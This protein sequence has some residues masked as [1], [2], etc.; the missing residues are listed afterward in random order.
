VNEGFDVHSLSLSEI[1]VQNGLQFFHS[2]FGL[3]DVRDGTRGAELGKRI[4]H[5]DKRG[6]DVVDGKGEICGALGDAQ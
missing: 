4:R 6:V 1:R 5:V 2:L 3:E